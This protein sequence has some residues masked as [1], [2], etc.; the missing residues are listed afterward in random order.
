MSAES[1]DALSLSIQVAVLATALD[2]LIGI[3]LAYV[4][5]R[6]NFRGETLVGPLVTLPP[7]PPPTVT[8]F[9]LILV[10]GRRGWL[11]GPLYAA[12]GWTIAFTWWGA[13]VAATATAL[14]PL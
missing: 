13:V 1:L 9:Y 14:P 12:T 11:G 8:G 7:V 2:A 4:L 5:A 10:I 3:P 6:R